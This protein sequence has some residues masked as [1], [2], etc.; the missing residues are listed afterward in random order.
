M[1]LVVI[2]FLQLSTATAFGFIPVPF[3]NATSTTDT[4]SSMPTPAV[5]CFPYADPH[6]CVNKSVCQCRNGTFFAINQGY[7]ASMCDPP[8]PYEYGDDVGSIPGFCCNEGSIVH[9]S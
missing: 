5:A 9:F 6:C 7:G 4:A 2:A 8:S 3:L 1:L